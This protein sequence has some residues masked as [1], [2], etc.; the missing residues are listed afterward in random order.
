MLQ[1]GL[2]VPSCCEQQEGRLTAA[3][4]LHGADCVHGGLL[5]ST[6]PGSP[7]VHASIQV[8]ISDQAGEL[9]SPSVLFMCKPTP[10]AH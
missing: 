1:R 4:S 6:S 2:R 5:L 10:R 9:C 8:Q 7:H 3:A